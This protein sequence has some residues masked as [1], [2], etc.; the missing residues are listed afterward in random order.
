[1]TSESHAA[2]ADAVLGAVIGHYRVTEV[3]NQGGMG[4]VYKAEH[5]LIGKPAVIKLLLPEL[6][7]HAE[8]VH[9]FFN[10]AKAASAIRHPGIVEI[11]DFGYHADGR[12]YIT[13]EFLDGVS[14]AERIVSRG[15]LP[16]LEAAHLTRSIA[17]ALAAA[18]AKQ[19]V[20]RDLKPD[21]IFLVPDADLPNGERTKVLDFGIA[22]L[23]ADTPVPLSR[24]RTGAVMGTPLYMSPE[25]ARGA[26]VIDARSDLYSV[27][28]LLYEMLCGQPP[29]LADGAGEIIAMQLYAE[30]VPPRELLPHLSEELENIVLALLAKEPA[31]RPQSARA[32]IDDLARVIPTLS[33]EVQSSSASISRPIV[34]APTLGVS[35]ARTHTSDPPPI[36]PTLPP[37]A[38]QAIKVAALPEPTLMPSAGLDERDPFGPHALSR[39]P[40]SRAPTSRTPMS[41]TPMPAELEPRGAGRW[42]AIGGAAVVLGGVAAFLLITRTGDEARGATTHAAAAAPPAPATV[43][44]SM[45]TDPFDLEVVLDG[46]SR[47]R[48]QD[49]AIVLPRDGADHTMVATAAGHVSQT[50]HVRADRDQTITIALAREPEPIIPAPAPARVEAATPPVAAP[51]VR[52]NRTPSGRKPPTTTQAKPAQTKPAA[53]TDPARAPTGPATSPN[54]SPIETNL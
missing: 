16:E 46:R 10:E 48:M 11:F 39:T 31:R 17:S 52:A 40:T 25:Q 30:P 19:I 3:L 7:S 13:M 21:N 1:M 23:N 41:R 54:G 2:T 18:H 50:L 8:M 14:L 37:G 35:R 24:T 51:H 44:L 20:H 27:G 34:V 9:R 5:P 47:Y 6:S 36:L 22:K 29:F 26:G 43:T 4:A 49:G 45:V 33:G 38:S 28:C 15:R 42:I 12:A 53:T 32:L